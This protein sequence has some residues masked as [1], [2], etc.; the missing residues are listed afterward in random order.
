MESQK[1]I[2]LA[3]TKE[4]ME[5]LKKGKGIVCFLILVLLLG[6]VSAVSAEE[7]NIVE[8]G[9]D[10]MIEEGKRVRNAVAIGGQ[11]T[12]FGVVER[13]VVA[14]GGS[15]VLTKTAVVGGNVVSLGGV[16]AR[17]RGAEVRGH[18][19][20]INLS[21]VSEAI[22]S[23]LNEGWKGWSWIFA[24]ISISIFLAILILALLITHLFPG[25][26]HLVSLAIRENTFHVIMGGLLVLVL[27]VPLALLLALSVVGIIL[28]PLEML[29]VVSAA[30][31]GFI[32]VARLVGGKIFTILKMPDKGMVQETLWGLIILWLIGWV[33]YLGWMVKVIAIVLGMGGV[34][35][36]RFGTMQSRSLTPDP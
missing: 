32:A 5:L 6:F 3:L 20:E 26:I 18:L 15:V 29:I 11:V 31:V 35:I 36:S 25:P 23:V 17:G 9:N 7:K 27:I 30:L 19:V 1:G 14:I 8:I 2:R 16:I 21:D 12:V 10:V 13:H 24:I 4:R 28:I 34:L 33:P 22:S